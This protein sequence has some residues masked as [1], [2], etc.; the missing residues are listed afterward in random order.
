MSG[1][2]HMLWRLQERKCSLPL[3]ASGGRQHPSLR[4]TSLQSLPSPLLCQVQSPSASLFPG[5]PPEH[6]TVCPPHL[7]VTNLIPS[8]KIFLPYE[9]TFT[10]S[11]G[12]GCGSFVVVVGMIQPIPL[13]FFTHSHSTNF[14]DT[15]KSTC[16]LL[17]LY[18]HKNSANIKS[19]GPLCHFAYPSLLLELPSALTPYTLVH[20]LLILRK[21]SGKITHPRRFLRSPRCLNSLFLGET[22]R[23]HELNCHDVIEK[24]YQQPRSVQPSPRLG[25]QA[26]VSMSSIT[27][28]SQAPCE[29][30]LLIFRSFRD[31]NTEA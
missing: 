13:L 28:S 29:V 5:C 23:K 1:G 9:V 20:S 21:I 2:L 12:L 15:V 8:A 4:A 22:H 25:H 31:E 16:I 17:Q 27:A 3:P 14:K 30:D 18:K 26:D 7:K 11:R 24:W 10:G 19:P 6:N